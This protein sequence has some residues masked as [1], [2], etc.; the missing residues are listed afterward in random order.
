MTLAELHGPFGQY[1][2]YTRSRCFEQNAALL[3][4]VNRAHGGET[5]EGRLECERLTGAA[6]PDADFVRTVRG[7]HPRME[8][9]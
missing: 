9:M 2:N 6:D 1:D 5:R 7:Y 4:H 8:A 3:Q